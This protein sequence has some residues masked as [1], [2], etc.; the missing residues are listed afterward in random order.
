M[1]FSIHRSIF[2]SAA[3]ALF[4]L[5]P[6]VFASSEPVILRDQQTLTLEEW[7]Q[8]IQDRRVVF[9]GESHDRYDHHLN[10]LALLRRLHEQQPRW[11]I[12]LEF[13]QQPFQPY[14]DAYIAGE[15]N[16][17][18]F[19]EKT[20]YYQRWRFDY[21]LYRPIFRYAAEHK[22]PL[23]ALN[24]PNEISRKVGREGLDALD[25]EEQHWL[26][27]S[28]DR[29]DEA[30]RLRLQAVFEEH[31][32]FDERNFEHFFEAQLLWDEAMA[33]RAANYL[34]EYPERGLIVLAGSGHLA[35]GSGIPQR[36]QRRIPVA[37]AIV[38]QQ[39]HSDTAHDPAQADFTVQTEEIILPP[40]GRIGVML[41]T[42]TDSGLSVLDIVADGGAQQAGILVKDRIIRI[43]DQAIRSMQDVR[44][45]MLDR[46]P[47]DTVQVTVERDGSDATR[48]EL[49]FDVLL[50]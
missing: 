44:L 35:Y 29:S 26:P 25:A 4:W 41:D 11:T 45:A 14:L 40:G 32:G 6:F 13:F 18:E 34:A 39:D 22:I 28:I 33:E 9:I 38:L 24:I 36:L 49:A 2:L 50:Q 20:E 48:Q 12:G 16:E 23:L 31:E 3:L 8:Q 15:I 21:R 10:Q 19:L 30:Y 27:T 17:T 5:Y 37:T 47:G 7:L 46:K 1:Q 42:L 43:N